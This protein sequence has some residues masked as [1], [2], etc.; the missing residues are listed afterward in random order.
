MKAHVTTLFAALHLLPLIS[1][2][3]TACQIRDLGTLGGTESHATGINNLG[4]VVGYSTTSNNASTNAFLWDGSIMHDLGTLGGAA[5]YAYGINDAGVVVGAYQSG[6]TL[7]VFRGT[8]GSL[9]DLGTFAGTSAIAYGVNAQGDV[10]GSV[11][12]GGVDHAFANTSA[13]FQDLGPGIARKINSKCQIAG[14]DGFWDASGFHQIGLNSNNH[15]MGINES[16]AVVGYYLNG[17]WYTGY[18]WRSTNDFSRYVP[19]VANPSNSWPYVSYLEIYGDAA[20]NDF[21]IIACTFHDIYTGAYNEGGAILSGEYVYIGHRQTIPGEWLVKTATAINNS[22]L[23]VGDGII[24]NQTHAYLATMIPGTSPPAITQQPQSLTTNALSWVTLTIGVSG[25]IPL[26][27]QWQHEATNIPGATWTSLDIPEFYPTN[28]GS[29]SV[30]VS[31]PWGTVVSSNAVLSMYPFIRTPFSG[32]IAYWGRDA[33]LA[34]TAW[35]TPDR[36]S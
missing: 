19:G 31:N 16:G 29:Y 30:I 18:L 24:S 25:S 10:V 17:D 12:V 28:L 1:H 15:A 5:S 33:T 6:A 13:G 2:A 27:I 4:W 7:R 20:V 26:S 36:K 34:I 3:Q 8:M 9:A 11:T 35:G 14:N 21:G 23:V 32:A 22:N